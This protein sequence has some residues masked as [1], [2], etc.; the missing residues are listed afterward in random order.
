MPAAGGGQK[1]LGVYAGSPLLTPEP[2]PWMPDEIGFRLS[3]GIF[4][5][6][7]KRLPTLTFAGDG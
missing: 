4:D 1:P 7:V 3:P 2:A 5:G 6:G